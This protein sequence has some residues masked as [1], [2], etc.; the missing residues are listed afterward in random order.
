[1]TLLRSASL[2]DLGLYSALRRMKKRT[3]EEQYGSQY[4]L[5]DSESERDVKMRFKVCSRLWIGDASGNL[6][7]G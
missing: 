6:V 5:S 2:G 7:K 1:M 4:S 3:E